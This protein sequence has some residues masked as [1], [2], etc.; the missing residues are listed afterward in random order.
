MPPVQVMEDAFL[1]AALNGD[2]PAVEGLL[3]LGCPVNAQD[4]V[5]CTRLLTFHQTLSSSMFPQCRTQSQ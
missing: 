5:K 2:L 1:D 4:E 3:A